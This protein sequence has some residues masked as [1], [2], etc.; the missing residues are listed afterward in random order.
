MSQNKV[1]TPLFMSF[2]LQAKLFTY[3]TIAFYTTPLMIINFCANRANKAAYAGGRNFI[4]EKFTI[5]CLSQTHVQDNP[6][7]PENSKNCEYG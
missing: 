4:A 6:Q 2:L 5:I 7:I 1:L 3:Y